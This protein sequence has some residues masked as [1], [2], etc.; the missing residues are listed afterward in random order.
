MRP[1]YAPSHARPSEQH[2]IDKTV[3]PI[4]LESLR[5]FTHLMRLFFGYK[6]QEPTL[7]EKQKMYW[8]MS[9]EAQGLDPRSHVIPLRPTSEVPLLR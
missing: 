5:F 4:T 9:L 1:E 6:Y 3:P 2:N 7:T 8:H